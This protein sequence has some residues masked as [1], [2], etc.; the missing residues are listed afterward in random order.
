MLKK[1][2]IIASIIIGAYMIIQTLAL[3][4]AADK[5]NNKPNIQQRE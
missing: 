3:C 5:E 4:K 2:L 1:I